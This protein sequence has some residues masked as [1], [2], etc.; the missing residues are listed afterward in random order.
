MFQGVALPAW[1]THLMYQ[2][3][4]DRYV[5]ALSENT[6]LT[7]TVM[8]DSSLV[9]HERALPVSKKE[10]DKYQNGEYGCHV[11]EYVTQLEND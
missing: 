3:E 10:F 8:E 2:D 7:Y 5:Y 9:A 4:N 1:V 6:L 11:V